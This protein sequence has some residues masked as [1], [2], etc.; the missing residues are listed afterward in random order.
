MKFNPS[1]KE[2]GVLRY[3]TNAMSF[4]QKM[5]IRQ[6]SIE[7]NYSYHHFTQYTSQGFGKRPQPR[8]RFFPGPGP[9]KKKSYLAS[10]LVLMSSILKSLKCTC[11]NPLYKKIVNYRKD[12]FWRVCLNILIEFVHLRNLQK[13]LTLKFSCDR[14]SGKHY[15]R[16]N[17][18]KLQTLVFQLVEIQILSMVQIYK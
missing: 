16:I 7:G 4:Y 9:V 15:G 3:Q 12:G 6:N 1:D 14:L 11:Q 17:I 2:G 13:C 5:N 8:E 18:A 10:T